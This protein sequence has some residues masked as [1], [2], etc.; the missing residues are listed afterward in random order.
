MK[1][2]VQHRLPMNLDVQ[3]AID[4]NIAHHIGVSY[5]FSFALCV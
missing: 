3:E 2:S 4:T 1:N 5:D